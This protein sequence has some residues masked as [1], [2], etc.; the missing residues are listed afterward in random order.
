MKSYLGI[1]LACLCLPVL[2]AHAWN[3]FGHMEVA[4]V[5]WKQLTPQARKEA[6]RLLNINPQH[7]TW[8]KGVAAAQRNQVLFVKAATWPDQIKSL[9]GFKTDGAQN[10]DVA[11]KTPQASQNI[12]YKDHFRHKYWHFIDQPFSTDGTTLIQPV[13]PNAQTQIATFR[14]TLPDTTMS[15]SIRSYD[16]AWLLHLIGDVHQPLHATSRFNHAEPKGDAGGNRVKISCSSSCGGANE[17]HA[18]WDGLLGK[19]DAPA[20]AIAAADALP[21]ADAA[22]AAL[23]DEKDWIKES[24]EIAKTSV[25]ASSVGNSDG[26]FALTAAYQKDSLTIAKKRVALAGA[27]LAKLLNDSFK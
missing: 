13:A 4:A 27:R 21:A 25:Y 2:P 15:D 22:Q 20:D 5:A 17:L 19:S 8:I 14:K 6:V 3:N 24:F 7:K 9:K 23:M 18:L 11:P 26:P 12:G 1:I 10:G 16:L